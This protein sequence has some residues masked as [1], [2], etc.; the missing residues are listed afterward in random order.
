MAGVSRLM[1]R[2]QL[3]RLAIC[4]ATGLAVLTADIVTKAASH[5]LI[6]HHYRRLTVV[7][8]AAIGFFLVF[9]GLYRSNLLALGAGFFL[10]TLL[11]NGGELLLHGYATDWIELDIGLENRIWLTNVADISAALGMVC[12]MSD[13]AF[14]WQHR[15]EK[16][17]Q[18]AHRVFSLTTMACAVLAL[19]AGLVSH[20]VDLGLIVFMA[21]LLEAQ[22]IVRLVR[23][24]AAVG[25]Q[26]SA[27]SSQSSSGSDQ[28]SALSGQ[29]APVP[30]EEKHAAP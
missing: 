28:L 3:T 18:P 5:P 25:H 14:A 22:V 21:T 30:V 4:L 16:R 23:R 10:G 20:S 15:R 1:V 9:L 8:F 24:Q 6:L 7:E 27:I 26:P 12:L 17:A 2:S 11:G 29:P 13:F 19:L